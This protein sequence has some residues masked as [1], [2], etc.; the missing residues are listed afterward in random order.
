MSS[1]IQFT[2][3]AKA[4]IM[5]II[6]G[7]GHISKHGE[8]VL[9][10][11]WK[12]LDYLLF[13]MNYLRGLGIS[14]SDPRTE[15]ANLSNGKSYTCY[16]SKS[17]SMDVLKKLRKKMYPYG[18]K[19]IRSTIVENM[20]AFDLAILILDDGSVQQGS[21]SGVGKYNGIRIAT[22]CFDK[23]EHEILCKY[24]RYNFGLQPQINYKK[25][26]PYIYFNLIDSVKIVQICKP[27]F[28]KIGQLSYKWRAF[29][30]SDEVTRVPE[31]SE[32]LTD[33]EIITRL[34]LKHMLNTESDKNSDREIILKYYD[35]MATF[36]QAIKTSRTRLGV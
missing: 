13:K 17:K 25:G 10:H 34:F 15:I 22:E 14:M 3:E 18:K 27:S 16:S 9:K 28:V 19:T 29:D 35:T 33:R 12:Q 23:N 36:E 6:L 24:L 32:S 2:K 26:N 7:D 31:G 1:E 20:N 5:G 21:S 8:I 30:I 4:R 11:S